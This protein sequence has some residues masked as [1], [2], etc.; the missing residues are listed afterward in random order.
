MP[1]GKFGHRVSAETAHDN[2][3]NKSVSRREH[4]MRTPRLPPSVTRK[5]WDDG[6][7]ESFPETQMRAKSQPLRQG[8]TVTVAG[9]KYTIGRSLGQGSYGS[10][11]VG[12]AESDGKKFALK[13]MALEPGNS[14][15]STELNIFLLLRDYCLSQTAAK[16]PSA[17]ACFHGY[18]RFADGSAV[19]VLDL[20]GGV[21]TMDAWSSGPRENMTD[22]SFVAF[23]RR[24]AEP[25][26]V[27][28][29]L[30]VTHGDLKPDNA[31]TFFDADTGE[32]ERVVLLDFGLSC[33]SVAQENAPETCYTRYREVPSHIDPAFMAGTGNLFAADVFSLGW[34]FKY[35]LAQ[36]RSMLAPKTYTMLK[37]L[38]RSMQDADLTRRPNLPTVMRTLDRMLYRKGDVVEVNG[39]SFTIRKRIGVG[40]YGSVYLVEGPGNKKKQFALKLQPNRGGISNTARREVEMLRSIPADLCG[41]YFACMIDAQENAVAGETAILLEYF[42]KGDLASFSR[43]NAFSWLQLLQILYSMA[44]AVQKLHQSGIAH[45]DLKSNNFLV[46][47]DGR[48]VALTDLGIACSTQTLRLQPAMCTLALNMPESERP[49]HMAPEWFEPGG[50]TNIFMADVYGLAWAFKRVL[51]HQEPLLAENK[52]GAHRLLNGIALMRAPAMKKR[53][54][55]TQVLE[56]LYALRSEAEAAGGG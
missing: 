17:V 46:H 7:S 30:G 41:R 53:T 25:L 54:L 9:E 11:H 43:K 39:K 8:A 56:G 42:S 6:A 44:L 19:L 1:N 4:T 37:S 12:T 3:S 23:L 52:I 34:S 2:G 38:V 40:S 45:L 50:V 5:D 13:R 26:E 51:D 36:Q 15:T 48:S 55:L 33:S 16:Q 27:L 49:S 31:R 22:R 47:Q 18:E 10:V 28:H 35:I 24:F 20:L 32:A 29:S 14:V 21:G